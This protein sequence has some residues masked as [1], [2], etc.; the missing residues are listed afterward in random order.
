MREQTAQRDGCWKMDLRIDASCGGSSLVKIGAK[1]SAKHSG[2]T[3][4]NLDLS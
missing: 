3:A 2:E 1:R 4:P